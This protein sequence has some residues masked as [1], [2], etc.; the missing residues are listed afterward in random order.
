MEDIFEIEREV[1]VE[2]ENLI[3][4]KEFSTAEDE[5]RYTKLLNEYKKLLRQMR[6]MVRMSDIMQSKLNTMSSELEKLSQIDGL[7]GL[8]NRRFFNE[9]YQREWQNSIACGAA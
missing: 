9:V 7:T 1:I 8:I 3:L 5:D 2:A 6:T 4:A